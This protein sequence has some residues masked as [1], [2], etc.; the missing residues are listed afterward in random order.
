MN[1][2]ET[3]KTKYRS[4]DPIFDTDIYGLGYTD[5]DIEESLKENVFEEVKVDTSLGVKCKV[6]TLVD[7]DDLFD[8]Y[9]KVNSKDEQIVIKYYIGENY[10]YGYFTGLTLYNKLG[11]STQVPNI[12]YI[13]SSR[14]DKDTEI[15]GFCITALKK[16]NSS[17][18]YYIYLSTL[19]NNYDKVEYKTNN[20]IENLKKNIKDLPKLKNMVDISRRYIVDE[21]FA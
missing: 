4:I 1:L 10:E 3:L 14:I 15:P 2:V 9:T 5:T 6:Y 13:A 8:M 7:Y 19:I 12:C 18:V 20:I 17:D 21:L 16:Y 11:I